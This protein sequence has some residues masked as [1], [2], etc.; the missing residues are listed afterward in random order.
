SAHYRWPML[1]TVIL[2]MAQ[3]LSGINAVFF[4]S[5]KM[6]AK[7]GIPHGYIPKSFSIFN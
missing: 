7:A 1:T 3:A 4:Y 6:F 2:Q 5:S